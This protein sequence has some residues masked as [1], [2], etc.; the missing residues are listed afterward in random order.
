MCGV[1]G[2]TEDLVGLTKAE[3]EIVLLHQLA[4][5]FRAFAAHPFNGRELSMSSER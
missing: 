5:L 4:V 3:C 1:G 2:R